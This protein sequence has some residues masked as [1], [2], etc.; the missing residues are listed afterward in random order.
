MLLSPTHFRLNFSLLVLLLITVPTSMAQEKTPTLQSILANATTAEEAEFARQGVAETS[1]ENAWE[2]P[3][4]YN[5]SRLWGQNGVDQDEVLLRCSRWRDCKTAA[6]DAS[7]FTEG[8]FEHHQTGQQIPP[9]WAQDGE[10]LAQNDAEFGGGLGH[11]YNY[12]LKFAEK[13]WRLFEGRSATEADMLVK[14]QYWQWC[15]AEPLSIWKSKLD[16]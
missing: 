1:I 5:S 10:D 3:C 14:K 12:A 4:P 8:F 7:R 13:N 9:E 2:R 6:D 16:D 15:A 11:T